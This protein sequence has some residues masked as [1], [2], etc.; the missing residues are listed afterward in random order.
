M[1]EGRPGLS[2]FYYAFVRCNSK[3]AFDELYRSKVMF[4]GYELEICTSHR[5]T[6]VGFELL[7]SN[8]P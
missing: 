8:N 3:A 4:A 6:R 2:D 7:W 1:V 5:T